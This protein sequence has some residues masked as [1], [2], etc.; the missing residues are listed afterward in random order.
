M[1]IFI[2]GSINSGKTTI[3][4]LLAKK[5]DNTVHIEVDSLRE[6]TDFM[7]LDEVMIQLNLENSALVAN[8]FHS[9]NIDSIIS[10]PL[11]QSNFDFL[12]SKLADQNIKS[13]ALNPKLETV[14]KNRGDRELSDWEK[15]RISHHYDKGINNPSFAKAIDNSNQTPEETAY[16]ILKNIK[17]KE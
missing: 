9:H 2:S 10:Y 11:S 15:E 14:S 16:I 6:F 5:L 17:S 7:P 13:F 12:K 4:K 8:N 1:I 3:S